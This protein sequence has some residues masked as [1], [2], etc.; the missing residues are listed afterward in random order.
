MESI[1]LT[2]LRG[3][4]ATRE[5]SRPVEHQQPAETGIAK[6][7]TCAENPNSKRPSYFPKDTA[8]VYSIRYGPTNW[9]SRLT[10]YRELVLSGVPILFEKS[11]NVDDVASLS[12]LR[13]NGMTGPHLNLRTNLRNRRNISGHAWTSACACV[14]SGEMKGVLAVGRCPGLIGC[15]LYLYLFTF[16]KEL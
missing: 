13:P 1:P 10:G 16:T 5:E 8:A 15:L 7:R 14:Y 11:S 3:D 9:W 12:G 4:G 6:A 2:N